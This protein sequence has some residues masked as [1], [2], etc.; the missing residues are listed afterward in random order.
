MIKSI[1]F[2]VA[3]VGLFVAQAPSIQFKGGTDTVSVWVTVLARDGS[4]ITDLRRDELE[5]QDDGRKREILQFSLEE[6]PITIA[7]LIDNSGSMTPRDNLD[8]TP[9][10]RWQHTAVEA[11]ISSLRPADRASLSTLYRRVEHLTGN[12][13]QLLAAMSRPWEA[14]KYSPIWAAVARE[15]GDLDQASGQRAVLVFTDGFNNQGDPSPPDSLK[16]LAQTTDVSLYAAVLELAT[17]TSRVGSAQQRDS[18]AASNQTTTPVSFLRREELRQLVQTTGG[19]S[20]EFRWTPQVEKTF[21][22]ITDELRFR[23]LLGFRT[24]N[25]DGRYHSLHVRT[26]R[27]GASVT[28]RPGYIAPRKGRPGISD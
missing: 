13:E 22:R 10:K 21:E 19:R 6:R 17:G 20:V 18:G 4:V 9:W 28:A 5:L 2:G 8:T 7:I 14:D 23:Y 24:E 16:K 1:R 11:V 26:S 3:A 15:V 25:L 12:R 27:R